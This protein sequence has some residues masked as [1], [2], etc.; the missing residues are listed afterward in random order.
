MKGFLRTLFVILLVTATLGGICLYYSGLPQE[1]IYD[2]GKIERPIIARDALKDRLATLPRE[3]L[4]EMQA[5]GK[6]LLLWETKMNKV[7]ANVISEVT[8]GCD[9]FF[10]REH[11]PPNEVFDSETQSQYFYHSHRKGEHGHFHLFIFNRSIL[12]QYEPVRKLDRK[13]PCVHLF[14]ISM[15]PDGSPLGFFTTNQ[16]V[17]SE[18]WYTADQVLEMLPSFEIDHPY[19]SW[20][21]NQWI[22]RLLVL[23]KP[24]IEDLIRQRDE[25]VAGMQRPTEELLKDKKVDLLSSVP[26]SIPLQ[27]EVLAELLEHPLPPDEHA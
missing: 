21:L 8:K 20:P 7:H 24:Q 12:D 5:A 26:V 6:E 13:R 23:F 25:V 22:N 4:L 27:M 19:P 18:N 10:V 11:Y 9:G 17:T 14:A 1:G 16:W 2:K 3:T 15:H